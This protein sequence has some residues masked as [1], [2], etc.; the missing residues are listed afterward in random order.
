MRCLLFLLILPLSI[1]S[2][3]NFNFT[4]NE[5]HGSGTY[6]AGDT[7]YLFARAM[8][9][10]EVFE[11]W[12]FSP[13]SPQFVA[14]SSEWRGAFIMPENDLVATANWPLLLSLAPSQLGQV[15]NQLSIFYGEHNF[16]A[17]HNQRTIQFFN[18]A[19]STT[20]VREAG[21]ASWKPLSFYPNPAVDR[22]FL[23]DITSPFDW[24]IYDLNGQLLLQEQ[25]WSGHQIP[26][27]QMPGIYL[28]QVFSGGRQLVSRVVKF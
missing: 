15:R 18:E 14:D 13:E 16:F 23:P 19:C 12:T 20:S 27:P 10:L 24:S 3:Q 5:G 9:D 17:N 25:G 8:A 7:A 22:V 6:A 26:L 2:A 4:V 11:D 21:H 28:L 1:L